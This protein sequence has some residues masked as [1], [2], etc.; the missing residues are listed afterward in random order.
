MKLSNNDSDEIALAFDTWL[1]SCISREVEIYDSYY[2]ENYRFLG[3][4]NKPY[5]EIL[6]SGSGNPKENHFK[7]FPPFFTTQP[8]D[9]GT[10]F[11]SSLSYDIVKVHEGELTSKRSL[12][13][14]ATFL[15]TLLIQKNTH[16]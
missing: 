12:G 3:F 1:S 2:E 14:G 9:S 8:T 11:K 7:I 6:D 13:K 16:G 5:L 15:N 4:K 10:G